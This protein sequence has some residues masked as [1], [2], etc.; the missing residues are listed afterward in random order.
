MYPW[1]QDVNWACIRHP[2][3]ILC[4]EG[5]AKHWT[6]SSV[7]LIFFIYKSNFFPKFIQMSNFQ[8]ENETAAIFVKLLSVEL[9]IVTSTKYYAGAVLLNIFS[10]CVSWD[11]I[12]DNESS[13]QQRCILLSSSKKSLNFGVLKHF[14][15]WDILGL[16]VLKHFGLKKSDKK[17]WQ[18]IKIFELYQ[19]SMHNFCT[20]M[21]RMFPLCIFL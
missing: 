10:A 21:S 6:N 2:V 17:T 12:F 20:K 13:V 1:K 7:N 3:Y 16:W 18:F 4:L 15:P 11:D 14:I 8:Y 19:V 5:R 9:S